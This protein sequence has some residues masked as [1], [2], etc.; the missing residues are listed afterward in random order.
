MN[1]ASGGWP[2]TQTNTLVAM[3]ACITHGVAPVVMRSA[4]PRSV[5][6]HTAIP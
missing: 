3:R 2:N 4:P 1:Q 6:E 5:V